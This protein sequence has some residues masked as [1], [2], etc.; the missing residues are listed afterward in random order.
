VQHEREPLGGGERL[1]HD[2]QRKT[3]RVSQ[4]R[5]V[6]GVGAI[7][8]VDDRLGYAYAQ[9]LLAPRPA[10]AEHVQRHAGGGGRQPSAEVPHLARVGAAEP[11]PGVL[12]GVVGLAQRAE[13][14]VGHGPQLRPVLLKALGQPFLVIQSGHN[15]PSRRVIAVD[16]RSP[17]DVTG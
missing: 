10:R 6:L 4:Q 7:H 14:P 9:G 3:D 15:A 2:Q 17:G 1:E 12:H 11:Q 5:L 16:P 13:H 8:A